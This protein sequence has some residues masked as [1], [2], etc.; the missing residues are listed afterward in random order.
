MANREF[1][2]SV[3]TMTLPSSEVATALSRSDAYHGESLVRR[4]TTSRHPRWRAAA[5]FAAEG[6]AARGASAGWG[7]GAGCGAD[8]GIDAACGAG[9]GFG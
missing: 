6:A 9:S 1:L 2:G 4:S 8:A 5:P 3:T 7:I